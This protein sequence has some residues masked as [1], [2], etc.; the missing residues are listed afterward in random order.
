[1]TRSEIFKSA[2]KT[3]KATRNN[4]SSY[5]LAFAAALKSAYKPQPI[6]VRNFEDLCL[7]DFNENVLTMCWLEEPTFDLNDYIKNGMHQKWMEVTTLNAELRNQRVE[8]TNNNMT[9]LFFAIK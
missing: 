5:K 3:A 8:F 9:A 1:M 4:F 6:K 2:H 7:K